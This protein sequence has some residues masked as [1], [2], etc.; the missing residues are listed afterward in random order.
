MKRRTAREL[1]LFVNRCLSRRGCSTATGSPRRSRRE[2]KPQLAAITLIDALVGQPAFWEQVGVVRV[3]PAAAWAISRRDSRSRPRREIIALLLATAATAG[4]E[5][6]AKQS[7][8]DLTGRAWWS[9]DDPPGRPS[10][11]RFRD[12]F[13]LTILDGAE[14]LARRGAGRCFEST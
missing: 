9:P 4:V 6:Y 13:K 8:Y 10:G 11:Y 5:R 2:F 7:L 12:D 1:T 14:L 3:D